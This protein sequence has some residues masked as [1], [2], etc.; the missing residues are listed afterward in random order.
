MAVEPTP[1]PARFAHSNNPGALLAPLPEPARGRLRALRERRDAASQ[2]IPP[3]ETVREAASAKIQAVQRLDRLRA[4]A[5]AAGGGFALKDTDPRVLEQ[6][7][8]VDEATEEADTLARR[9]TDKGNDFQAIARTLRTVEQ[10]V[11]QRPGNVEFESVDVEVRFAKGDDLISAVARLRGEAAALRLK[12]ETITNAPL[13]S[14]EAKALARAQIDE[15]ARIGAPSVELLFKGQRIVFPEQNLRTTVHNTP[16]LAVGF[17]SADH[18]LAFTVWLHRP[19][20]ISAIEREI[21]QQANDEL[22]LAPGAK[23]VALAATGQE[24]SRLEHEIC[25]LVDRG[26]EQRL[27]LEF[28]DEHASA[29]LGVQLVTVRR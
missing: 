22:A 7:R 6:L 4:P 11:L 26:I 1:L 19:A 23:E 13:P 15:L 5:A 12:L 17:A 18:A 20:V 10:W 25:R 8:I 3:G 9:Y 14:G 28:G 24:L 21:D 27:P 2:A 29:V 16:N